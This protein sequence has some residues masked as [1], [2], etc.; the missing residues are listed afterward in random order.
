MSAVA[1]P[2]FAASL[3]LAF[4]GATKLRRPRPTV[5]AL[6]AA[7]FPAPLVVG[8]VV[9][10]VELVAAAWCLATGSAAACGLVA[11][12]Y[13]AFAGFSAR[14]LST[15]GASCGCFGQD[16]TPASVT[17]VGVNTA[18][19]ALAAVAVLDPPGGLI[20]VMGDQPLA[21]VPLILFVV[22]GAWASY[23]ALTLLPELS[24]AM[25]GAGDGS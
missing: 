7:G 10:A 23:L 25:A 3:L 5:E 14:L 19:G 21:G 6:R 16:D 11:L 8:R 18:L 17:H 1:G 13:L 4:A 2:V 22:L 9:G 24:R 20:D 12:S 15:G